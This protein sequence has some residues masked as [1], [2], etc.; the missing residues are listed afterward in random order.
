MRV[1]IRLISLDS[2][3]FSTFLAGVIPDTFAVKF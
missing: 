1:D 2:R 3:K